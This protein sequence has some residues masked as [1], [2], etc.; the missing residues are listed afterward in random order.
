MVE[1]YRMGGK[2]LQKWKDISVCGNTVLNGLFLP[3]K[4]PYDNTYI[5]ED[6]QFTTEMCCDLFYL[7]EV[8]FIIGLPFSLVI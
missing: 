3:F 4:T 2:T 5:F 7:K 1:R 6:E 8:S